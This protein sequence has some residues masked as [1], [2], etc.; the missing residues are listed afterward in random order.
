MIEKGKRKDERVL[1]K[2]DGESLKHRIRKKEIFFFFFSR[3]SQSAPVG[4][5]CPLKLFKAGP[6]EV[7]ARIDSGTFREAHA[8]P[9]NSSLLHVKLRV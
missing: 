8:V 7:R 4:I 2:E 9:Q 5:I 1:E 3:S 6:F